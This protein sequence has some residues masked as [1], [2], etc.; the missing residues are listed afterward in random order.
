MTNVLKTVGGV[1]AEFWTNTVNYFKGIGKAELTGFFKG[2]TAW[3]KTWLFV[4]TAAIFIAQMMT[5]DPT[6]PSVSLISL[7]ASLSGIWCVVLV[8]KGKI[9]NYIFGLVN[10]VFYA[11]AAYNWQVYGDFMLNA[12]YYLP[13]QFYGWYIWTKPEFK[14]DG[15]TVKAKK[16]NVNGWII[17]A[18]IAAIAIAAYGFFL[19]SINNVRPFA[20]A[21]LVVCSV[22]AQ[23]LM[24]KRYAE[25][26]LL[27]IVVDII[28]V[29]I[30]GTVV[31]Q[32]GGMGNIGLLIM[33]VSWLINAVYGYINWLKMSKE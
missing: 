32:N 22:I 1:F 2:W 3:Q 6:N 7:I 21:A 16:L 23:F 29:Y 33:Y 19:Q 17:T 10:V 24:V 4:S 5:W 13:M 9:S 31:F 8:A 25:Q 18:V 15:D 30:W 14:V 27:W 12:F 11:W 26:W 20:D 28:G